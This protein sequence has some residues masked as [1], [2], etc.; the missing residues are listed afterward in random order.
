MIN[1]M[2]VYENGVL[3]P[4]EPLKWTEGQIVQRAVDPRQP[5][6]PLRP[7]T[8]EEAE[9]T[10]RIHATK[11]LEELFAVIDASAHTLE[12]YDVVKAMNDSRRLTGFR[13]PDPEPEE[14]AV[15]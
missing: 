2:A 7:P 13:M 9:F 3:T 8:A 10:R 15:P 14:G 5:V 11:T 12:E 4:R 6:V 1:V